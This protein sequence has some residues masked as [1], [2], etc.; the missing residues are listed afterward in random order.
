MLEPTPSAEHKAQWACYERL[1]RAGVRYERVGD[2]PRE[3]VRLRGPALVTFERWTRPVKLVL[4]EG[5]RSSWSIG[6]L[7]C[8]APAY[9]RWYYSLYSHGAR[10]GARGTQ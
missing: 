5:S 10:I 3:R 8:D 1:D 7:S 4:D 2:T 9:A 6:P